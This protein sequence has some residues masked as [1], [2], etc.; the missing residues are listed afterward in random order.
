MAKKKAPGFEDHLEALQQVVD[1]LETGELSLD[2]S[3]ARYKEGVKRL[4]SCHDLLRKAEDQVKVLL[5][6]ADG[7]VVEEPFESEEE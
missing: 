3:L 1:E 5:E 4:E 7:E 6:N 2:E